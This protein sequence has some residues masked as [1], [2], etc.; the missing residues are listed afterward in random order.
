MNFNAQLSTAARR[1]EAAEAITIPTSR[2]LLQRLFGIYVAGGAAGV[3]VTMLL[4]LLGY[5]FSPQQWLAIL[6]FGT[7]GIILYT[8]LDI[9]LIA[10]HYR[11][12][13]E[14]LAYFDQSK[15]P[16]PATHSRGL[17]CALNLP[18]LSFLRISLPH[19][20]GAAATGI[21]AML[22]GNWILDSHFQAWQIGIFCATILLF[23][24]P[25]HAIVEFF[26]LSR[27]LTPVIKRLS[28][29]DDALLPEDAAKLYAVRLRNKLSYLAVF[30]STLPT[31]F[32][33][34]SIILK[35]NLLVQELNLPVSG[36]DLQPI[37]VWIGS[38]VLIVSIGSLMMSVLT[39]NEVSRSAQ[40]LVDAMKSVEKGELDVRLTVTGTDEYAEIFRGFNLMIIGLRDEVAMLELTHDLSRELHIDTLI[41][42]IMGAT[43]EL[44]DADRATLLLHDPK[45][46]ELWSRYA[47]G[48]ETTEIRIAD[49]SGVAGDVFKT[50]VTANLN[51]PYSDPRFNQDVDR[52]TGY[53]TRNML[54]M[55]VPNKSGERIAVIQVLNK[56]RPGGFTAK[57]ETRLMAFSSQIAITLENANLFDEVLTISNYNENIR[58]SSSN[59]ILTIDLDGVITTANQAAAEILRTS[60]VQ[61]VNRSAAGWFA[62]RNHWI[63]D[64]IKRVRDT[65]YRDISVDTPL[66]FAEGRDASVNLKVSPLHDQEN[67]VI[68]TLVLIEDISNEQRVRATMARFMSK[69]V[70]DQ[71][72]ASDDGQLEGKSQR[73]SILFSDIRGFT[74]ISE[75]LGATGTVSLL[76]EYFEE[77]VEVVFRHGG[78]LDK[79][80]GDA[81]MALFGAPFRSENDADKAVAVANEMM[82]ALRLL[83][84]RRISIGSPALDIGIGIG[85][86]EAVIGNI[87]STKRLEYTAIGDCVNMSSRLEGATKQYGVP[88]LISQFTVADLRHPVNLR[89]ID[90]IRVKGKDNPVAVYEALDHFTPDIFPNLDETV[91][92]FNAGMQHYRARQF[93]AA[94]EHFSDALRWH[95]GDRPSQIF[96]E[97][98]VTFLQAPP[99]ADWDGVWTMT[100]K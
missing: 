26:W 54:C 55:A 74:G 99:P 75:S 86:G 19:A 43:T 83:N 59:G 29:Y 37:W 62:E 47:D 81:I 91:A 80:I 71:L 38:A 21:S 61:L 73:I 46:R 77:M 94:Q 11:P 40:Q 53:R 84:Q 1:R 88:I 27:T 2:R 52:Q 36:G 64:S 69:E 12:L 14:S 41:A 98:C 34:S 95:P 7:P 89:E 5:E 32:I 25:A 79:Y 70:A 90:L 3:G 85:T 45:S 63:L 39:A 57:D 78:I 56:R 96:L 28:A 42:R 65:G 8:L 31:I 60:E 33:A 35:L 15:L 76:N 49:T 58:A 48:L 10:R 18:F 13:G 100:E 87:G 72:L 93:S 6:I 97:R 4:A 50:G 67:Q 9:W 82:A 16:D 51:D 30:V 68:G 23:A 22:F 20:F 92:A 44:L 66:R 24:A 17:A